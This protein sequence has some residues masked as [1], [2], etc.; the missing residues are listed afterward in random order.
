MKFRLLTIV[1]T[2]ASAPLVSSVA[3]AA[4]DDATIVAAEK[5]A[6]ESYKGREADAFKALMVQNYASVY[7]DG[8]KDMAG[9]LRDM[10]SMELRSYTITNTKVTYPAPTVAVLTYTCDAQASF[11]GADI[12]GTYNCGSVYVKENGKW[13]GAFHAEMKQA[14]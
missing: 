14:K 2:I 1:L 12:S 3:F 8:I 6:W 7:P 4:G 9:E 5:Q 10:K 13:L 11:N